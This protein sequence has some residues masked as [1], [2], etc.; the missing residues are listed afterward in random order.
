ML[1]TVGNP[2][3]RYGD[4]TITDGNLV[5]GTAGK[6]IDFS[7]TSGTGTSELL[8]DYE[9]GTF[10]A[11]I[12]FGGGTTGQTYSIRSCSYTKVGDRVSVSGYLE[13]T[14]KGSSTGAMKIEGLPF[15]LNSSAASLMPMA[16]MVSNM[17]FSGQIVAYGTSNSDKI[18]ILQLTEAGALTAL[19]DANVANNTAVVL[20]F[21]YQT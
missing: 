20:G 7:A 17:T 21:T 10:Q 4:Q 11:V 12:T 1:K 9:E 6:G 8:D 18:E 5:I 13:F 3:V 14:N 15:L 16:I 19:T 2:P